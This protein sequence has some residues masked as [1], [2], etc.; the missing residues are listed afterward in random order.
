M[1]KWIVPVVVLLV[2]CGRDTSKETSFN[3]LEGMWEAKTEE[4][5]AYEYWSRSGDKFVA[6]GGELVKNDTVFQEG[7][8]IQ[9]INDTWCYI[10][11]VGKQGPVT[12]SL[13]NTTDGIFVF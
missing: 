2:A 3:W 10:P 12:F 4:G 9:K 1:R 13:V 6:V 8:S 11:I 5:K 7:I